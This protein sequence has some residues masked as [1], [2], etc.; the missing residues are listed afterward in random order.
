MQMFGMAA[1]PDQDITHENYCEKLAKSFVAMIIGVVLVFGGLGLAGWNEYRSVATEQTLNAAS[2][3]LISV[4]C[5]PYLAT[6]NGVLVHV[7]CNVTGAK[8][9]S[10]APFLG[11]TQQK[12]SVRLVSDVQIYQWVETSRSESKKDSVGGGTT[13]T[14]TYSYNRQWQSTYE[15]NNWKKPEVC[16]SSNG[17]LPCNNINPTTEAGW[18]TRM[19]LGRT[20]LGRAD[21][22]LGMFDVPDDMI[23]SFGNPEVLQVT[24]GGAN[25]NNTLNACPATAGP[26]REYLYAKFGNGGPTEENYNTRIKY[27]QYTASEGTVLAAQKAPSSRAMEPSFSPWVGPY[28]KDYNIYMI[29]TG[30]L[31]PEQMIQ[32]G[33]DENAELTWLLRL[34]SWILVLIGLQLFTAPLTVVGDIIPCIGPMLSDL[35][36]CFL[37]CFNCLITTFCWLLVVGCTWVAY[38]P[39]VGIPLIILAIAAFIGV[40]VF[41]YLKDKRGTDAALSAPQEMYQMQSLEQNQFG[42]DAPMAMP[43]PGPQKMEPGGHCSQCGSADRGGGRFCGQC[44]A[45]S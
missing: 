32:K 17:G 34:I 37:C 22:K 11:T 5:A 24:C 19:Q 23:D 31:T 3:A 28:D 4:P 9:F 1:R 7:S 44:G 16:R 27:T 40:L 38:R 41:R 10:D 18:D 13:T 14:T 26:G 20:T 36:G 15:G 33:R 39:A 30:R 42:G 12:P 29:A 35:V 6:N 25:S 43:A 21:V 2:E 8:T 45:E